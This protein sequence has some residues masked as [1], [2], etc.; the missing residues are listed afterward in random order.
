MDYNKLKNKILFMFL[1][2]T[3]FLIGVI[4]LVQYK[5]EQNTIRDMITIEEEKLQKV[6]QYSIDN[7]YLMYKSLGLEILTNSEITK[8]V[9]NKDREKLLLLTNDTYKKM[10]KVNPFF[11]NMHFHTVNN[12][13]I[14]RVH[15]PKQF[16]DDL[17]KIRPMIVA[18][19]K[20]KKILQG[21]EVGKHAISFRVAFPIF[22]EDKHVGSLEFGVKIAYLNK[23]LKDKFDTNSLFIFH[24]KV[25][26]SF[27][28]HTKDDI[29][30]KTI[31]EI[32]LFNYKDSYLPDNFSF[33]DLDKVLH[34]G[35]I[36]S[37][38]DSNLYLAE[39]NKL[40]N[41]E[42]KPIGHIVFTIDMKKFF[43]KVNN[44]KLTIILSFVI[45]GVI[46]LLMLS[47][48]FSFFVNE[49]HINQK[50]LEELSHVDEL[51]GL[52]NRRKIVELIDCEYD[53]SKRYKINDCIII[54]DIDHFKNVN[55]T[56]GHNIGD[57]ILKELSQLLKSTIRKTD[58]LGRWGGE[59]FIIIA[60][61][62]DIESCKIFTEKLRS[63]IENFN[64][65]EA[66][67]V[68]CS[69]GIAKLDIDYD[70]KESIHNSDLALYEAKHQG[71]NKVV[72]FNS[73]TLVSS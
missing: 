47:K 30:Y 31:G 59:E 22:H 40:R 57:T 2:L 14:A 33:G 10:K 61:E 52:F 46:L 26:T 1:L 56:Y 9:K 68:T 32:S 12:I 72:E 39:I 58:H 23:L 28:K 42:N 48:W 51:T 27:F 37:L 55:D 29:T 53:R 65:T 16:G 20:E 38:N 66:G 18:V 41:Y 73:T 15:K 3:S 69:F 50:K 6:Y 8:A 5:I 54:F 13:S 43:N 11:H 19:N 64:F 25:L 60:T 17:S 70:Y 71:R 36:Y 7:F 45:F 34:N 49:V 63:K 4:L 35:D 62:T 67:Q 21:V 44:Y 24:N